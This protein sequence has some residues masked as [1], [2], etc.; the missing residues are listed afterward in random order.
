MLHCDLL[1]YNILYCA[2]A[3]GAH[4]V[5]RDVEQVRVYIAY[6]YTLLN[7][8]LR[9]APAPPHVG[10]SPSRRASHGDAARQDEAV[11]ARRA[12]EG[13]RHLFLGRAREG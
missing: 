11:H 5:S 1:N 4:G 10:A 9:R 2:L 12:G 6:V 13:G 8:T 3:I 7:Y